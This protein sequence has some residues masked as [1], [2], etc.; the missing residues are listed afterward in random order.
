MKPQGALPHVGFT[1]MM[2]SACA[3]PATGKLDI[4]KGYPGFVERRLKL[5][6]ISK[7]SE[8]SVR[9]NCLQKLR[10]MIL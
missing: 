4:G 7:S 3:A 6:G 1:D 10:S 8:D 5:G 2:L 9:A